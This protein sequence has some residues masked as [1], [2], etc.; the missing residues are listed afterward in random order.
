MLTGFQGGD[1]HAD[2]LVVLCFLVGEVLLAVRDVRD[3]HAVL[4]VALFWSGWRWQSTPY[5]PR[6]P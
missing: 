3:V 6:C 2:L 4:V 1:F 5:C